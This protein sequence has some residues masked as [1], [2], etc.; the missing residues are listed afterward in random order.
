METLS[1]LK[2]GQNVLIGQIDTT[3]DKK[4]K[5]LGLGVS[6][7]TQV[8]IL[9][10]RGGDMVVAIGNARV[11]LGRTLTCLIKAKAL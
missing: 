1:T 8:S 7:G 9:R 4:I 2:I 10:N 6:T 3:I 5:L 11:S